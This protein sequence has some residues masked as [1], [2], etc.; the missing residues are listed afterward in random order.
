MVNLYK[1]GVKFGLRRH[2]AAKPTYGLFCR[3]KIAKNLQTERDKQEV[4]GEH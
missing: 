3:P 4:P 1:G 2:L